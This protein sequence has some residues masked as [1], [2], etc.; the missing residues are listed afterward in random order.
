MHPY[1]VIFASCKKLMMIGTNARG[2]WLLIP[3]MLCSLLGFSQQPNLTRTILQQ[4]SLL[5]D[6]GFNRCDTAQIKGL[7][8]PDFEFYHDRGGEAGRHKFM[9]DFTNAICHD[10]QA[11]R[12]QRILLPQYSEVFP[13][14]QA[15]TLYAALQYGVHRFAEQAGVVQREG[16]TAR[17]SHLWIRH[18]GDWKLHRVYSFDHSTRAVKSTALSYPGSDAALKQIMDSFEI[19][20]LAIGIIDEGVLQQLRV[21]GRVGDGKPAAWNSIF[22]VA[23]LA[24]PVTAMVALRL[25]SLGLWD[26]QE[27]L[28]KYWWIPILQPISGVMY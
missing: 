12:S 26:I 8:S 5:F 15:D 11:F 6:A 3:I 4:D 10:T 20:G 22:N 17:F 9:T 2:I 18:Q 16:S 14:Y 27:P 19:K 7:L 25:A 28:A 24:K 21:W 1:Y 13:L 23:S